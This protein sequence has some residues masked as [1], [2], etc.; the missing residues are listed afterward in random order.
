MKD[1]PETNISENDIQALVSTWADQ[2]RHLFMVLPRFLAECE[3]RKAELQQGRQRV[4]ELEQENEQLRKSRAALADLYARFKQLMDGCAPNGATGDGPAHL[5]A[6]AAEL[7]PSDT[8]AGVFA[9]V[10]ARAGRKP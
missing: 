7:A 5:P 3:E 6:E 9:S 4:G 10:F 2:T 1:V 8:E